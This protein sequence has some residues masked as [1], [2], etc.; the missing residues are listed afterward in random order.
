M[1]IITAG[2]LT[3]AVLSCH[4]KDKSDTPTASQE[5]TQVTEAPVLPTQAEPLE[6]APGQLSPD[7]NGDLVLFGLSQ[8]ASKPE[9]KL[10]GGSPADP[11]SWPASFT[12]SQNGSRCTGTMVGPRVL[13]LA[14]HCVGNG[15]TA[16]I[17][18]NGKTYASTCT[19]SPKYKNDATADYALCLMGE[20]V[21]VE[22]Y[23]SVL[24]KSTANLKV[25]DKLLLAGMGCTK[26]GGSGGN[27]GVFR[28]GEAPITRLPTN[29]N[30][31]VT[32]GTSALCY[33]DSGGSVFWKDE[34]GI[35]KVAGI[36]SRGDIR[37]VSY[38]SA[39]FT[40]DGNDFYSSWVVK[41]NAAICGISDGTPKCRG[42]DIAPPPVSPVPEWCKATYE[43]V[44][45]CIFGNPRLSLSNVEGCRDEYSKLFACQEASELSDSK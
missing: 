33:G 25:G 37:S 2:L 28:I 38:L 22:W 39:V 34:K 9:D 3:L 20:D 17:T 45:K 29:D 24:T 12:T 40:K 32:K 21:D 16:T 4:K 43:T 27:D 6:E 7:N 31:I 1:K 14:A 30:D 41:N 8:I 5:T 18:A 36:N 11:K 35:Y 13:Q 23:E 26:P 44:G 15:R 10:I 42:A 19:H